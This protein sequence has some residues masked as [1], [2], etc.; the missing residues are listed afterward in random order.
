MEIDLQGIMDEEDCKEYKEIVSK[1]GVKTV[2]SEEDD[3]EINKA[4]VVLPD[5]EECESVIEVLTAGGVSAVCAD[6]D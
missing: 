2:C 5:T 6:E 3:S 4:S 1:V